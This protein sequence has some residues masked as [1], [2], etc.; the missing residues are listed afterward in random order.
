[1]KKPI[2]TLLLLTFS[3]SLVYPQCT[4]SIIS[5][6]IP[7]DTLE[8]C[9]GDS[10]ELCAETD[11]GDLFND[12]FDDGILGPEWIYYT[13][14][15]D[16]TNPCPP[17][18][19]P[20][21]GIVCWFNGP[22]R[23][24]ITMPLN[25]FSGLSSTVS[26]A[27]KY[28]D[29]QTS[30][31]CED[32]DAPDEG[33]HLQ[34][35]I[36]NGT[37]WIDINYWP[38]NN[39]MSGP[40]YTWNQYMEI[41]PPGAQGPN[42][43]FRWVQ[44]LNSG[45]SWDTW[46]IDNVAISFLGYLVINW[47]TGDTTLNP[48]P[49]YP[50]Q[51]GYI[52]C[53]VYDFFNGSQGSDSVYVK[54]N[55]LT[56]YNVTGGGSYCIGGTGLPVGLD[57][58]QINIVYQLYRNGIPSSNIVNGTGGAIS[59]GNQTLTG[60]YT[61]MANNTGTN[62]SNI[63][64]GSV[65]I[66]ISSL[67]IASAGPDQT[68]NNGM[69]TILN[70]SASSGTP[71]YNW[72]WSPSAMIDG[73]SNIQNPKTINLGVTQV[74]SINVTDA[75]GCQD[76]DKV[77]ISISGGPLTANPYVT[78]D[79]VCE[80]DIVAFL[81]NPGGGSGNYSCSWTSTPS[82]FFSNQQN[83]VAAPITTTTY[84]V[85]VDD[86]SNTATGSV[87]VTVIVAPVANAGPDATICENTSFCLTGSGANYT[88]VLWSSNGD[89][90]FDDNT[91]EN[92]VYTPGPT[93]IA[94]GSVDF[95][96][97]VFGNIPCGSSG[98]YMKL[99]IIQNAYVDAGPDRGVCIGDSIKLFGVANNYS[100]ILWST[101]GDGTFD[102]A[103]YIH[104]TYTPGQNDIAS[105]TLTLSLTAFGISPC[106][107]KT[108]SMTLTINPNPTPVVS[109]PLDVCAFDTGVIYS[110]PNIPGNVYAWAA[111]GGI[112]TSGQGTNQI[113]V[114]WGTPSVMGSVSVTE[115]IGATGCYTIYPYGFINIHNLPIANAGP[116]Q[117]ISGNTS[118]QLDG[119]V[120]LGSG[121]YTYSWSPDTLL[122]DPT[123]EDPIT[124]TLNSTTD[125]TFFATD[126][127]TGC[128][129]FADIVTIYNSGSLIVN[130]Q[131]I[132]DTICVGESSTLYANP[133]G[134]TSVYTYIWLSNPPGFYSSLENPLVSPTATT[135]YNLTVNDGFNTIV[136]S[137]TLT[138]IPSANAGPDA[139]ICEGDS[140]TLSGSVNN[141]AFNLWTTVGD[142]TFDDST[143]PGAT[144]QPGPGDIVNGSVVLIL[145]ADPIFPCTLAAI[146]T[147]ILIIQ[148]FPQVDAGPDATICEG[149]L[150]TLGGTA[151]NQS[152]VLWTTSG[153]GSFNNPYLFNA[154]YTP[155]NNDIINASVILTLMANPSYPCPNAATDDMTLYIAA[156]PLV[157]L[158]NDTMICTNDTLVLSAGNPGCNYMWSTTETT[159]SIMVSSTIDAVINYYVIV[160]DN[161]GCIGNDLI[162]VT[163]VT[164]TS[165]EDNDKTPQINIF[166]NPS[167]GKFKI[168]I[169]DP[170]SLRDKSE[171]NMQ[172][173]SIHGQIIHKENFMINSSSFT[174]ELDLSKLPKGIY[175]ISFRNQNFVKTE[176]LLVE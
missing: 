161:I 75:N 58:S 172:I 157:D 4:V 63:M 122:V 64:S 20:A 5:N 126:S 47:S 42:T 166:P 168:Q 56:L 109:G 167:S 131:A 176:K 127:M 111:Y 35:S 115:T 11:C 38:P 19:P 159:E 162:T 46:G 53:N 71:P 31:Y 153:D 169:S 21:S 164:C 158:G 54:V 28:G 37:G 120:T 147:M 27:M 62:C 149:G 45:S 152:S 146:D 51:S 96:F 137:T 41:I 39:N 174:K 78:P 165:L 92:A 154:T 10:I 89:G 72:S 85:T 33:V 29:Q 6:N 43:Q 114:N 151:S 86:G 32:P 148:H 107:N 106:G 3:L 143:L 102:N 82:G 79:T 61:V 160:T 88:D 52:T 14:P 83:P 142:G 93:D 1:M 22:G 103:T 50:V 133:A 138:V 73:S 30:D 57:G 18:I 36:N 104:P 145:T 67:P 140:Y 60:I 23:Y 24:I 77:I 48:G 144:Y 117:F 123:V 118:T 76:F 113:T 105:G 25:V 129:S 124:V 95:I 8:V 171:V 173:M 119:T 136:G 112:V 15:P 150:I 94:L 69:S 80:G 134:G 12:D 81:A 49:I 34:Y 44:G 156:I 70:G 66:I 68:I 2:I 100:L 175:F 9:L 125:F 84:I 135:T 17:T 130:P 101:P 132:P 59:F 155:G 97:Q 110:T 16:F 13:T 170:E 55:Q 121:S 128:V 108:S 90:Y 116:D 98:D 74:F 141:H 99:S 40:L 139:A 7:V 87:T 65:N 26:F 91:L 163:F